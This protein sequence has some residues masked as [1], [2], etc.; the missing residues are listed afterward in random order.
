MIIIQNAKIFNGINLISDQSI[1]IEKNIIKEINKNIKS[2]YCKNYIDAKKNFLMPGLIDAHFHANTPSYDFYGSDRYPKSYIA[3][4][5]SNILNDT[6]LRGF[7]TVRDAGGGDQG[8]HMSLE[9]GVINGPRFFYPGKAL[10]QTGG[11]GDMRKKE[12]IEHC[13]CAYSG[14]ITKVVDGVDEVRKAIREEF[15]KGAKHIKIFLSGGVSTNLAPLEMPH[16]SDEEILTAVQETQRRNSYVMAHCHTDEG[17]VRCVNLGIRSIEHGSLIS[18]KTA[19]LISQK[20][21]TYVVPTL[22]AGQ[23]IESMGTKLGLGASSLEKV[24]EVNLKRN[25][26]IENCV[27]AGVKLGLGSDLHGR[28]YL[29]NQS[30]ELILRSRMQ[31]NVD[32]LRSATSIN[33]EIMQM[34]NKLGVI[35]VGALADI[36]LW[37]DNP[38]K[39]INIFNNPKKHLLLIIKDGKINLN[40]IN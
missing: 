35:K 13:G 31:K 20:K 16:F 37:N 39:N 11:H 29:I 4:H 14:N 25:K 12:Y 38:I 1:L 40:K 6:L 27:K 10:T 19:K 34:K 3:L 7:T 22:S 26:A 30:K 36:I 8:L 23:L 21:N 32:V 15:R 2:Q 9:E 28:Q 18:L 5:A 33:A 17:A 24:K